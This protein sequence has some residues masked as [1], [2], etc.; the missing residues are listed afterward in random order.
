MSGSIGGSATS[1]TWS[2][3]GSGT[4]DNITDLRATYTPSSADKAAGAVKLVLTTND[5]T[6]ICTQESDTIEVKILPFSTIA[7]A[8][9]D[10]TICS[11]DS[12]NL[13]ATA[14]I[15][16]NVIWTTS[17]TGTLVIIHH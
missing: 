4:F 9:P 7:N 8:G 13:S 11:T 2:T 16:G 12:V 15:T 14:S 10:Q 5:P 17:G 1:A 3:L 6:G